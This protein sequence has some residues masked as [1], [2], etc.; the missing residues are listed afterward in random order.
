MT[1]ETSTR[2]A[3]SHPTM[4]VVAARHPGGGTVS[5]GPQFTVL[6]GSGPGT[7]EWLVAAVDDPTTIVNVDGPVLD[8]AGH[9]PQVVTAVA[10][11]ALLDRTRAATLADIERGLTEIADELGELRPRQAAAQARFDALQAR[12]L[13]LDIRRDGSSGEAD[14]LADELAE[15]DE[16]IS[17]S[18]PRATI[19]RELAKWERVIGEAHA[20]LLEC[21]EHAPRACSRPIS[22]KRC[23]CATS[24]VTP[25]RCTASSAAAAPA[26]KSTS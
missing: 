1:D 10:L 13:E 11:G 18:R 19:G 20:R 21:H 7:A 4:R 24:G 14:L 23:A 26:A 5:F 2:P 3:P 9:Q 6:R 12:D 25:S 15:L 17:A 16:E 8:H 22:P